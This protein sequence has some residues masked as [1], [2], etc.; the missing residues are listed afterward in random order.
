MTAT[1]WQ[2]HPGEYD[3]QDL[4]FVD[5]LLQQI[6]ATYK[7]DE[8]QVFATGLSNGGMF[9]YLLLVLRPELFAAFSPVAATDVPCPK[10]ARVPRPVLITHG[11]ADPISLSWAQRA[12][13]QLQRLNGC[14]PTT[15]AAI[16]DPCASVPPVI[17]R[18]HSG[19][20]EWPD[21]TTQAIVRFFKEHPLSA[22]A[23]PPPPASD[24]DPGP[25]FAGSGRAGFFGEGG[26]AAAARFLFPEGLALAGDGGLFV[27]DTGNQRIRTIGPDGV[28]RT[29]AGRAASSGFYPPDTEGIPAVRAVEPDRR[30]RNIGPSLTGRTQ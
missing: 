30:D 15:S 26:E 7:V 29:V 2:S 10:W 8:R 25:A 19:G 11:S 6:S 16:P 17:L 14:A 3:D 4:R 18:V 12:R 1:G 24:P 28:I 22:P 9:C 21:G 23:S 20:H 27:A 5:A 13:N